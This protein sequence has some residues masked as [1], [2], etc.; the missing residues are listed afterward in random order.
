MTYNLPAR[1]ESTVPVDVPLCF[2]T[3]RATRTVVTDSR[4]YIIC[5]NSCAVD[6][7]YNVHAI[8]WAEY[9]GYMGYTYRE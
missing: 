5:W 3:A 1:R 7:T 6:N 2:A 9:A 8:G 4:H